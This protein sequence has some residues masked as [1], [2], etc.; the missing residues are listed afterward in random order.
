MV[1]SFQ[2]ELQALYHEPQISQAVTSSFIKKWLKVQSTLELPRGVEKDLFPLFRV[3][4][5]LVDPATFT[6]GDLF[7][8]WLLGILVPKTVPQKLRRIPSQHVPHK[9]EH[10]RSL[11]K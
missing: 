1:F 9:P 10:H 7:H 4:T 11:P 8:P 5:S 2:Y 3:L 6:M